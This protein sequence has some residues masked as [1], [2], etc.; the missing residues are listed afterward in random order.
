MITFLLKKN[1][2][3]H[4]AFEVVGEGRSRFDASVVLVQTEEYQT[5]LGALMS[6]PPL[7]NNAPKWMTYA[8]DRACLT[9]LPGENRNLIQKGWQQ[10]YGPKWDGSPL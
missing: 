7:R 3:R 5:F 10:I 1:L 8:V 6:L 2:R 9:I 4:V